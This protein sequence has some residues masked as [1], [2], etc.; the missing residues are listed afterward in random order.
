[1]SN[2]SRK[3]RGR[4]VVLKDGYP[5]TDGWEEVS[6][7]PTTMFVPVIHRYENYVLATIEDLTTRHQLAMPEIRFL[8]HGIVLRFRSRSEAARFRDLTLALPSVQIIPE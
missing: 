1:M 4:A 3:N 5:D 6:D 2:M 8:D 7:D